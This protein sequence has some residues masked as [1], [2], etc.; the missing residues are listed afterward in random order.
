M[1]SVFLNEQQINRLLQIL[2]RQPYSD[3][4][5][6][7]SEIQKAGERFQQQMEEKH[8]QAIEAQLNAQ[9]EPGRPQL[10][11]KA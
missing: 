1:F 4:F 3:V 10:A 6:L 8:R 11:T 5:D 7:V 9:K 2:Q